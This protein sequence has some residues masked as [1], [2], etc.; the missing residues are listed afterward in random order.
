MAI[1]DSAQF[2][3]ADH[4]LNPEGRPLT[5]TVESSNSDVIVAALQGN[6]MSLE[7]HSSGT[8][9]VSVT[10]ANSYELNTTLTFTAM[11]SAPPEVV[12]QIEDLTL[13][14]GTSIRIDLAGKFSDPENGLLAYVA[15][16]TAPDIATVSTD[17]GTVTIAAKLPGV[18]TVT[19]T[20]LDPNDL[21]VSLDFSVTVTAIARTRWGS[22][23][24]IL[25][26]QP[27]VNTGDES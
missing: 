3:L 23:R 6:I 26:R 7:A 10:A 18:A 13:T 20:A 12:G 2:E 1:G 9:E 8:T 4:F 16:S 27:T 15:E 22:W 17:G 25:L 5:Y 19:V 21:S 14:P 24:S 11:V